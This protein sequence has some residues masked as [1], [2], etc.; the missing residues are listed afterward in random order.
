M[1]IF[2]QPTDQNQFEKHFND[3]AALIHEAINTGHMPDK[4]YQALIAKI[5][6]FDEGVLRMPQPVS[7]SIQS[8][9][10]KLDAIFTLLQQASTHDSSTC[11]A[12]TEFVGDS[13]IDDKS[14]QLNE[15]TKLALKKILS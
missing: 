14:M 1:D 8:N 13:Y 2:M 15:D 11:Q 12:P 4:S 9:K 10:A 5:G 6:K 3:I 7:P